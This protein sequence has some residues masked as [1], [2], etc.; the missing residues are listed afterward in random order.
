MWNALKAKAAQ[1]ADRRIEDM[2]DAGRAA[3]FAVQAGDMRLD[4]A[5]TNIDAAT[6]DMLIGVLQTTGVAAKRGET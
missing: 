5:K 4:Y 3:D 1:V 6:R 2:L